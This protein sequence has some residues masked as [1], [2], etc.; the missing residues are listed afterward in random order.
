[1]RSVLRPKAIPG[2]KFNYSPCIKV[3]PIYQ[4][5][6]LVGLNPETGSLVNGGPGAETAQI[7]TNVLNA[8]P[9]LGLT[10]EH[11]YSARLFTTQFDRFDDINAAWNIVF[12][13]I[14]P[15]ARTAVGVSALPIGASVEIEFAFY[16]E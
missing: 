16:K 1:M 7:L 10:L 8:L 15:P 11:L 5:A 13:D 6:G 9:E 4:F 2:P 3:G 14:D 12:K